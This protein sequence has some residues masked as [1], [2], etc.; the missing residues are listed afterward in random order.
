MSATF[1]RA[2]CWT[3]PFIHMELSTVLWNYSAMLVL[4]VRLPF[5]REEL[6]VPW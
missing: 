5:S 2:G 3:L 1:L 4:R 6:H